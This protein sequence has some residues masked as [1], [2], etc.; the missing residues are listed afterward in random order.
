[1]SRTNML[2]LTEEHS[3]LIW[4]PLPQV[5]IL[6]KFM[7]MMNWFIVTESIKTKEGRK[8]DT[9]KQPDLPL[10]EVGGGKLK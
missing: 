4:E 6:L 2:I 9:K 7:W 8:D 1:M 5:A 3:I 10:G